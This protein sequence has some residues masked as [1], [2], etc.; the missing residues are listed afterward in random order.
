MAGMTYANLNERGVS[1]DVP[2]VTSTQ[3]ELQ[4]RCISARGTKRAIRVEDRRAD[5]QRCAR[6]RDR[7]AEIRRTRIVVDQYGRIRLPPPVVPRSRAL[8]GEPRQ[9]AGHER[10]LDT[11]DEEVLPVSV[12]EDI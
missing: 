9:D 3:S 10:G 1:G 8:Q 12:E 7:L 11:L 5:Q 4:R 6:L 2:V